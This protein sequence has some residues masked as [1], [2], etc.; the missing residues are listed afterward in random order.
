MYQP[1]TTYRIQFHKDFNFNDFER[2]I[3]YLHQLGIKTIYA[4]PIFEAV[5]GS[6]HGYDGLNPN[7]I[8]PE[9]GTLEQL[10][11]ISTELKNLGMG[12]LQ[13]FVSNHMAYTPQ[14]KWL[15]DF[16]EKGKMSLYDEYFDKNPDEP[17]MA[18]FLGAPLEQVLEEQEISIVYSEGKLQLRYFDSE[19]PLNY[20]GYYD[21]LS[22]ELFDGKGFEGLRD[23]IDLLSQAT[24]KNEFQHQ[25]ESLLKN[26]AEKL[27][28]D[29]TQE[30][31][32]K[33]LKKIS[34]N[35]EL[36]KRLIDLQFYRLCHWKET[37]SRINYRRFFT[38]NS[39][40]CVH[41]Q[42]EEVF[43]DYHRLLDQLIKE[44]IIQGVRIDHIDGLY[45]P[46][47]YLQQLREM[48]GPGVYIVVEKI[49]EHN[50]KLPSK[51][52]VQGTSGY[53]F[54]AQVNNVLTDVKSEAAF[55]EMYHKIVMSDE[56]VE[57]MIR[58]YKQMILD[59]YMSGELNNLHTQFLKLIVNELPENILEDQIK[60]VIAE[61]LICCPVYR[62][63]PDTIPFDQQNE[64]QFARLIAMVR[65]RNNV[66]VVALNF[67]IDCFTN[68][69]KLKDKTYKEALLHFWRRCMQLSGPLMAKGVEDTLMY[70]YPKLLAHNE[71]GSS[72]SMFGISLN[73][74]HQLMPDKLEAFPLSMNATSTHDT[75]RGE[76]SRARL[77]LLSANYWQWFDM[78]KEWLVKPK[79]NDD[80]LSIEDQY[81]VL[82]AVYGGI[83]FQDDDEG[84]EH[85]RQRLKAFLIKAAREAKHRSTWDSP[86]E[87]YEDA[88]FQYA[89]TV[90]DPKTKKGKA[91]RKYLHQQKRAIV[92]QSLIQLMLKCTCPGVP[93]IYQGTE[94]WDLS[95]V[96]PDNRRPVNYEE[97]IAALEQIELPEFKVEDIINNPVDP[98][99]KLFCLYKLLQ[100]RK[101][102]PDL[103]SKGLYRPLE[104]SENYL[105]FIRRYKD[106]WIV[107]IAPLGDKAID[108]QNVSIKLPI[109]APV[110]WR[111]IFTGTTMERGN[112]NLA[113]ELKKFPVL[114][115]RSESNNN[116]RSAG[117]LL[118]LFSLPSSYGI[119]DM[120]KR[121]LDFISFLSR[122][123]Q[124]LWQI[125]PLNPV[126]EANSFSPYACSSAFAGDPLYIDPQGLV[127]EGLLEQMDILFIEMPSMKTVDYPI[128]RNNK[129]ALLRTAWQKFKNYGTDI[130][131]TEFDRFCKE[132]KEWLDDYVLYAVLKDEFDGKPWYEWPEAFKNRAEEDIKQFKDLNQEELGLQ[133]WMQFIFYKQWRKL[134]AFALQ[135]DV[136]LVG[137]I[138]FYMSNDS[139]DVWAY[140]SLFNIK[141]SGQILFV[142]GVPPDYF[143]ETGQL[144]GM[145]T[146]NWEVH[147]QS[148]YSWW[149]NRLKQNIKLY[150]VVRLD[151]F[152]A[153]YDYWE[154]PGNADTAIDGTWKKGPQDSLFQLIKKHF[155]GMPF[156]AEDLGEIHRGV[157]DFKDKYQLPGMR[158]LQFGFEYYKGNLRDLPHN[159]KLNSVVY[160]GTHDNNTT[161]GWF[162]ALD[163]DARL[164]LSEYLGYEI[165]AENVADSMI[166]M[167]YSSVAE[168]LIIPMQDILGLDESSRVN[169]PS[170][171]ENNWRWRML[172]DAL[173]NDISLRLLQYARRYNRI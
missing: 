79:Q 104:I 82:Q 58:R 173:T 75:K 146:Y 45:D 8:N 129:V 19:Y 23:Q 65:E 96:D 155:P 36:L 166:R 81:F 145:P 60:K 123:G 78:V 134:R 99:I 43:K 135:H 157:F 33:G 47:K 98:T 170:T 97:R 21:I 76:D 20:T 109:E 136:K 156:I 93:D 11:K 87:M 4:S 15:C 160:T 167:A 102:L 137:D 38:I 70:N 56:P 171:I 44:D 67:F 12:W 130:L 144:W 9:I 150:D 53:D 51:W 29:T 122:S 153:F 31:F 161:L 5:P 14:N 46:Y 151:H 7:T 116:K 83:D 168:N 125:L 94:F 117:I 138:P 37:N 73:N 30:L 165:T 55:T 124:K 57:E 127:Q 154:I 74:F 28:R 85:F 25:W 128:V 103:F 106:D 2:I 149:I 80:D 120:G 32:R 95:F 59:N 147:Q 162:N 64:D 107:V 158:I 164:V 118:P 148:G 61:L 13:D 26:L 63:Y 105:S 49:L 86:N 101:A 35:K 16:L 62:Y 152:R 84:T 3:P 141:A 114:V 110:E 17:L 40:I 112:I 142:A 140:K 132:E 39:L 113:E 100:L 92:T 54:L 121:A 163:G 159:F 108:E 126:L 22:H 18:P 24:E 90:I 34:K 133:K 71:V 41:I 139:A 72:I 69:L 89:L 50:E 169:T 111:N 6:M 131:R 10:R 91:L 88:L 68:E 52:P 143:S 77:Q 115:L 66:N 1:E 42:K 48:V 172:P 119:G 27:S